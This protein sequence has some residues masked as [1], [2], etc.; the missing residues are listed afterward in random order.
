MAIRSIALSRGIKSALAT[1]TASHL[2][3]RRRRHPSHTLTCHGNFG[4]ELIDLLERKT[5]GLVDHEV[6][7]RDAP[8][9]AREPDEEDLALEV[10]VTGSEV[11]QERRAVSN[12]PVE[13][14]VGGGGHGQR[15]CAHL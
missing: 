15:L 12:R 3:E 6:D 10:C 13:Q 5:L 2:S 8:E 11:D 9:A 7:K 1:N 14:P 4:I